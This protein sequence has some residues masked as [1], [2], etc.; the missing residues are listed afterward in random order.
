MIVADCPGDFDDRP[1]DPC[2]P[3]GA[4]LQDRAAMVALPCKLCGRE[5]GR[6]AW[7]HV[8]RSACHAASILHGR[9]PRRPPG[10]PHVHVITRADLCVH[11]HGPEPRVVQHRPRRRIWAEAHVGVPVDA[12]AV[13]TADGAPVAEPQARLAVPGRTGGGGRTATRVGGTVAAIGVVRPL[14]IFKLGQNAV[15]GIPRGRRDKHA[16][17]SDGGHT[18]DEESAASAQRVRSECAGGAVR[19]ERSEEEE[20][21]G[22]APFGM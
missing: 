4:W 11:I 10:I 2:R 14:S 9:S 21:A 1:R 6:V 12:V 8:P 7:R 19:G 3:C 17:A 18:E 22:M 20:S 5:N 16:V 13:R 15:G